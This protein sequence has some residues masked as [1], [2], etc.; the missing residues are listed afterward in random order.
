MN[1]LQRAI[2]KAD[3]VGKLKLVSGDDEASFKKAQNDFIKLSNNKILLSGDIVETIKKRPELSL[4]V[5]YYMGELGVKIHDNSIKDFTIALSFVRAIPKS[6]LREIFGRIMKSEHASFAMRFI[7][8]TRLLGLLLGSEEMFKLMPSYAKKDCLDMLERWE[9]LKAPPEVLFAVLFRR[10]P[11]RQISEAIITLK[12]SDEYETRLLKSLKHA[13]KIFFL[14]TTLELKRYIV[15]HGYE[16]YAFFDHVAR[17]EKKLFNRDDHKVEA[18]FY[19][20]REIE[21]N[22][23]PFL[24]EHLDISH[25]DLI[26][27]KLAESETEA[28]ILKKELLKVAVLRPRKNKK[29]TLLEEAHKIRKNPM[30]KYFNRVL[31]R[32]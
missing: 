6:S 1:K 4:L 25:D 14:N 21:E 29:S 18:R 26:G 2:G 5:V 20:L 13:D 16:D 31:W 12:F 17:C 15:K 19:M 3:F 10:F 32:K 23:E 24:I 9:E 27:E 7:F 11:T 8:E 28:T 22:K 30:K